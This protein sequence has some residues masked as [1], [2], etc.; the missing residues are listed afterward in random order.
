MELEHI[1]LS[2]MPEKDKYCY[3]FLV[4]SKNWLVESENKQVCVMKQK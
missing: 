3:H 2:E 4:E 1:I